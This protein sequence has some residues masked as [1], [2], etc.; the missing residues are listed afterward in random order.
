MRGRGIVA[1]ITGIG[2]NALQRC[3]GPRL[4]FVFREDF[5]TPCFRMIFAFSKG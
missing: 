3:S 1:A 5:L 2:K 4:D